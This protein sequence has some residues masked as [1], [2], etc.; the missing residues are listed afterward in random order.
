MARDVQ[1]TA[2]LRGF[3]VGLLFLRPLSSIGN[4]RLE[5]G[6]KPGDLKRKHSFCTALPDLPIHPLILE[7]C[8][9]AARLQSGLRA[10]SV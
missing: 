9:L 10:S 2:L 8:P 6:D 3:F 5:S 7:H 1:I 4:P